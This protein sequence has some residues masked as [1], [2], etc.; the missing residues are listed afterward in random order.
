MV[1][2]IAAPAGA[3]LLIL[4]SLSDALL[5]QQASFQVIPTP[6]AYGSNVQA[7][8]VS[9][10]G[11]VIIGEYFV[12]TGQDCTI[13]GGCTRTFRWTAA[14]GAQDLGLI[15]AKSSALAYGA[16]ADGS[17]IVGAAYD[18]ISFSRAFIWSPVIGMQ[19]L[20]THIFTNDS[21][22]SESEAY[23]MSPTGAII[24]GRADPNTKSFPQA[25][26]FT[27]EPAHFSFLETLAGDNLQSDVRAVS[28]DGAVLV[29]NAYDSTFQPHAIRWKGGEP[30]DI[31]GNDDSNYAASSDGSVVV[32]TSNL[33][34]FRWTEATGLQ[35]L[36]SLSPNGES[37][38]LA[39]SADGSVVVGTSTP[40]SG[41]GPSRAIRWTAKN[42]LEDL[43]TVLANL[44]V[45]TNGWQL[46]FANG[47]S[48]DGRVIVGLAEN[49]S[50]VNVV[51]L[52]VVPPPVCAPVTCASLGKNCGAISDGCG[53]TLLCGSCSGSLTCGGG[54]VANVCGPLEPTTSCAQQHKNCGAIPD[55]AGGWLACGVCASPEF[56]GGG[57]TPNVCGTP[58]P[59]PASLTF[60]L[61]SNVLA[62]I[63]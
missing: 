27:A 55:G 40:P 5:A 49:S 56:C 44:G 32:G 7:V 46:V 10:D 8:G 6:P 28:A 22:H 52:A 61:P 60:S 62:P 39:V 17:Q 14:A 16:S 34:A 21:T 35:S 25:L 13:A 29:G 42:G 26:Q 15:F 59:V 37:F 1:R 38:A 19:D 47:M 2:R 36:G 33:L 50:G 11:S 9:A 24:A 51:Y 63:A 45:N 3:T 57:G 54:G 58:P 12:S 43:N 31:G 53:G 30:Q 23:A 18:L 48:A 20:G 41:G 4:A